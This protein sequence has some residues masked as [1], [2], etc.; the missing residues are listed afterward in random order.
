[1]RLEIRY[2]NEFVYAEPV[3]ESHNLLRACPVEEGQQR[4]FEYRVEVSPD[5]RID[6]YTDYWGTRV[7]EFGI[8]EPHSTLRVIAESVVET[9]KP[10]VP[11][12]DSPLSRYQEVAIEL[13]EYLRSSPHARW[14]PAIAALAEE[15]VAGSKTVLEAVAAIADTVS[16]SLAYAPGATF[17]GVDIGQ[18]LAQGKG[19]CQDFAHLAI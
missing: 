17:V 16:A 10:P 9:G 18:V 6:S 14:D 15:S 13:S 3:T 4:R 8:R 7:D 1:M 2:V 5:A 19:V 11:T 12:A